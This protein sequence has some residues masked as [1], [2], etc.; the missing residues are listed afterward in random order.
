[1]DFIKKPLKNFTQS[2]LKTL[3]LASE[4]NQEEQEGL[5]KGKDTDPENLE[6]SEKKNRNFEKH[7][8]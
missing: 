3:L 5:K 1:M 2:R 7:L 8:D 4:N 6:K